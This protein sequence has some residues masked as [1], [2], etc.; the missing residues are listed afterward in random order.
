MHTGELA[1]DSPGVSAALMGISP[2]VHRQVEA[3]YRLAAT[4]GALHERAVRP[5][6][7]S[8]NPRPARVVS[9]LLKEAAMTAVEPLV[10]AVLGTATTLTHSAL[11]PEGE[12]WKNLSRLSSHLL[13]VAPAEPELLTA[14]L[15]QLPRPTA[16]AYL[17]DAVRHLHQWGDKRAAL[18]LFCTI[19]TATNEILSEANPPL[20][21]ERLVRM[22]HQAVKQQ[23]KIFCDGVSED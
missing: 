12:E 23:G 9:L 14:I 4:H 20:P 1:H 21:S 3:A 6:G 22:L 13:Q 2:E 10:T 17:L 7:V 15:P 16:L 11:E 19:K 5:P 8:F 18:R